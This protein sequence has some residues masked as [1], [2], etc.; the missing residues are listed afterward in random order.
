MKPNFFALLVFRP[1][2]FCFSSKKSAPHSKIYKFPVQNLQNFKKYLQNPSLVFID[3]SIYAVSMM[4]ED[5]QLI[6][7]SR[8]RRFGKSTFM[9]FL[10]YLYRNGLDSPELKTRFPDLKM[11]DEKQLSHD[12]FLNEKIEDFKNEMSEKR[13]R[14]IPINLDFTCLGQDNFDVNLSNLIFLRIAE[15]TTRF[16]QEK[17]LYNF[18]SSK[19]KSFNQNMLRYQDILNGFSGL[20]KYNVKIVLLIDEYESPFANVMA[21]PN[22]PNP[23]LSK[24]EECYRSFFSFVKSLTKLDMFEKSIMTGVLSFK[25]LNIFSGGN[26]Y[27]NYSFES[28]YAHA[29][30]FTKEELLL[31]PHSAQAIRSVLNREKSQT[32]QQN[33]E[34]DATKDPKVIEFLDAA[35]EA[36]NGFSFDPD[37]NTQGLISPVSFINHLREISRK[38]TKDPFQFKNYWASTGTTMHIRNFLGASSD[39]YKYP[40]LIKIAQENEFDTEYFKENCNLRN[41]SLNALLFSTGYFSIKSRLGNG[42]VKIDWTNVETRR[43][44]YRNY[45]EIWEMNSDFFNRF[46]EQS[47]SIENEFKEKEENLQRLHEIKEKEEK[48]LKTFIYE[49]LEIYFKKMLTTCYAIGDSRDHEH[50]HSHNLFMFI[51][52][53]LLTDFNTYMRYRL[54]DEN[55]KGKKGK[56]KLN[57]GGEPDFIIVSKDSPRQMILFEF[58]KKGKGKRYFL[59][60]L[61]QYIYL[62]L[63]NSHE[64]R[65]YFELM[66]ADKT[67]AAILRD[68][69][70]IHEIFIEYDDKVDKIE[71]SKVFLEVSE[72]V[73]KKTKNEDWAKRKY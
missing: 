26:S 37:N 45:V 7:F 3:K 69:A 68:T 71:N 14:F 53:S 48:L 13:L 50:N 2:K 32:M 40:A 49:N 12:W 16:S 44:F 24:L 47:I 5:D 6:Y 18:L 10:D 8:P 57:E 39:P 51:L 46:L 61:L 9:M 21:N 22:N 65:N 1:N 64:D 4:M 66:K 72:T 54:V 58:F 11:F 70:K 19:L 20:E 25:H 38:P 41:I 17:D 52:E 63:I 27:V 56:P 42:K 31:N 62:I 33:Q 35:I 15:S 73:W 43:A 23:A 28:N 67:F 55:N 34:D 59:F 36:Y 29:F 30:G 60:I